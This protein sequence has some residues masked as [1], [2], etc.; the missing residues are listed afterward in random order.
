M[1][2]STPVFLVKTPTYEL[3]DGIKYFADSYE[4]LSVH[5]T[6]QKAMEARR[7]VAAKIL[8]AQANSDNP[9]LNLS[10]IHNPQENFGL[11]VEDFQKLGKIINTTSIIEN[12]PS[13]FYK[14]Y[15][16]LTLEQAFAL[17]DELPG[18]Y[19]SLEVGSLIL[20]EPVSSEYLK[21]LAT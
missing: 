1:T 15:E 18:I 19:D 21:W 4:T 2:E 10:H 16:N 13:T 14:P 8:H 11:S 17:V 9:E 7:E 5:T 12:N 20:D 3:S 6:H